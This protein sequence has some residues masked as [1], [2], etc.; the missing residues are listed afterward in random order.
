MD[1]NES[2]WK[3]FA[4]Q[5]ERNITKQC[6]SNSILLRDFCVSCGIDAKL[7][8]VITY[9]TDNEACTDVLTCHMVVET[10][11][12]LI[13]SSYELFKHDPMYMDNITV[14]M[15]CIKSKNGSI[16]RG[17]TVKEVIANF[18][19]F[20]RLADDCNNSKKDRYMIDN[21][22]YKERKYLDEQL[23]YVIQNK[24]TLEK[25]KQK[26]KA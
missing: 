15:K 4:F 21:L 20:I 9:H 13:E 22:N 19:E 10:E 5:K 6:I 24:D 8:A 14:V 18:I 23:N 7:K 11:G 25:L 3:M 2:L 17:M 1:I 12:G 26:V 16:G